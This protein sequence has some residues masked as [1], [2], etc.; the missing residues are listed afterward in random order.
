MYVLVD[1]QLAWLEW[2][3]F[4]YT[5]E[6]FSFSVLSKLHFLNTEIPN[7]IKIHPLEGQLFHAEG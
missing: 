6:T 2:N 3:W 1:C 4:H 7:F 5:H